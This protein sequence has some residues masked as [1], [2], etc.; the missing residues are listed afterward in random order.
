VS[1]EVWVTSVPMQIPIDGRSGTWRCLYEEELT[2]VLD[3]IFLYN[4]ALEQYIFEI[5]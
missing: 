4:F 2:E 3:Y 5:V 1:P